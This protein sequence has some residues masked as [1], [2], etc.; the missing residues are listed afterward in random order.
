MAVLKLAVVLFLSAAAQFRMVAGGV[1]GHQETNRQVEV[2]VVVSGAS[3]PMA[4]LKLPVTL[5]AS[6]LEPTATLKPPVV[7]S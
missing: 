4:V 6:A 3:V 7:L 5:W 1:H 2:G